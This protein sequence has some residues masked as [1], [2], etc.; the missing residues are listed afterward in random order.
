MNR[1][2]FKKKHPDWYS[3]WIFKHYIEWSNLY[4]RNLKH[5]RKQTKG[6]WTKR[7]YFPSVDKIMMKFYKKHYKI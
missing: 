2:D 3:R 4:R 1:R 7:V 6:K 5:Q